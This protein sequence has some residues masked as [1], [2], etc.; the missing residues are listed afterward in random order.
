MED[1]FRRST[2]EWTVIRPPRLVNK[3]LTGTYRTVIGSSVPRGYTISRADA[4]HAMLA[5]LDNP[6]TIRQPVGIAY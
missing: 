4:A 2:V 5:V 1:E 3:P 6:A